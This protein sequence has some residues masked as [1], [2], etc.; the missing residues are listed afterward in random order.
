MQLATPRHCE[1][2]ALCHARCARNMQ[3]ARCNPQHPALH[4]TLCVVHARKH[5]PSSV[6]ERAAALAARHWPSKQRLPRHICSGI[7]LTPPTSAQAAVAP[8][9][10]EGLRVGHYAGG[11]LGLLYR[12]EGR[13]AVRRQCTFALESQEGRA[14]AA[15]P[16]AIGCR[17]HAHERAPTAARGQTNASQP[18]RLPLACAQYRGFSPAA[19]H[20]ARRCMSSCIV[21]HA[22]C[23]P[24]PAR[25][26]VALSL[27]VPCD[28]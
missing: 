21:V 14:E 12:L 9:A 5:A 24:S 6:A 26:L 4:G 23:R 7:G 28:Y 17:P 13:R 18:A 25:S 19:S 27:T 11:T 16:H 8:I 1:S 20:G 10:S 3:H 15:G 2:A 22:L